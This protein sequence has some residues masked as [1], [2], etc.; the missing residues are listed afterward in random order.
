[1]A[2]SALTASQSADLD[3]ATQAMWGENVISQVF[4]AVPLYAALIMGNRMSMDGG[5][6]YTQP[7]D[8]GTTEDDGQFYSDDE[9]LTVTQTKTLTH[10]WWTPKRFQHPVTYGVGEYLA[11]INASGKT[12]MVDL[13]KHMVEKAQEGTKR[14]LV[15]TLYS[16]STTD[17]G[18][19]FQSVIGALNIDAT[20]GNTTRTYS[21]NTNDWW[22]SASLNRA[23]S[24][25]DTAVSL[26]VNL[27]RQMDLAIME[28][29]KSSPRKLLILGPTN[30]LKLKTQVDAAVKYAAPG[31]MADLK[32]GFKSFMLDGDIEVLCD[33]WLQSTMLT[34]ETNPQKWAFMLNL[35]DWKFLVNPSRNFGMTPFKW[36]GDVANGTDSWLARVL[37]SGNL[38][39]TRPQ[40]SIWLSDVT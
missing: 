12:K 35:N 34:A 20:Y 8:T 28:K 33:Y 3:A 18:K 9:P 27:I 25:Q 38:I 17:T 29:A 6:K 10:P 15:K 14:R 24:D 30:W 40:G 26:S 32:Y 1:M 37:A 4:M 13:G 7:V 21:S 36:Q 19:T 5:D 31:P 23:F 2:S 16:S 39:C 11:N 22:Q